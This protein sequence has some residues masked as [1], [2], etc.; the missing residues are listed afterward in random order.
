MRTF[1]RAVLPVAL[2][3]ALALCARSSPPAEPRRPTAREGFIEAGNGVRLFYRMTG[4]GGD[5]LV[6]LHGGP[7][8]TL[9]YL[10]PDLEPLAAR[11]VVIFYDQRGAGR[12]TLVTDSA[13]L[14]AQ[15]FAEDLEALRRHFGLRRL[16]LLGHS[17]GAGV[18][19]LYAGRYPDRV[20]RLLIVDPITA[21]R[22]QL[23]QAFQN[24][25]S[26][27]DSATQHR[28]EQLRA[29]RLANPGDA[30]ACRAYY[31]VWFYPA[32]TDSAV[33]HRTRGDFCAGTPESRTNKIKSVDRYTAASLGDWD[34]RPT[35]SAVTAPTLVIHG[36][37]DFIPIE[38]ARDWA[39]M[40]NGRLL[41]L[42]GS[43]HFPYLEVPERFFA[44]AEAFLAGGWPAG[45]RTRDATSR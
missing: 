41:V 21:T 26:R 30:A 34:W 22:S 27:R 29:A 35:L 32:F 44:A 37:D 33:M 45:A 7:G 8:F 12:S 3:F 6:V 28:M 11:H 38:S 24:L 1:A 42:V 17:W 10:A 19:A 2:L 25:N 23:A 40:P 20:G 13:A 9:D 36:A 18:A 43:G 39:A 4:S 16:T 5:T 15:R 31:E 14:D